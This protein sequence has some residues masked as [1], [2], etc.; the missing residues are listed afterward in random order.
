[1][2]ET[3][4]RDSL[5]PASFRGVAFEVDRTSMPTGQ[6]GQLHEFV[7]RDEPYFEQ[8]GKRA[9]VHKLTAFV[10]GPDCF[11]RRDKLLEALETQGAG[12]LVHP[13]FGRMLVKVGECEVSHE[14]AEGGMV[15]FDL[16]LYPDQP[17]KYPGAKPNT[18]QRAAKAS[19]GLLDSALGRYSSAIDRVDA[20]RINLN[21]LRSSVSGVFATVQQ[22]FS[23]IANAVNGVIGFVQA[24]VNAPDSLRS[25]FS[26]YFAG[27][28]FNLFSSG[29]SGSSYRRSLSLANQQVEA[30]RAID[31]LPPAG[32]ADTSAAAQAT[33]NLVQ[34][35]LLVQVGNIV[36]DLPVA[37][38][39][40]P[41][42]SVPPLDQQEQQPVE[43]PEVPVADDVLELRDDLNDAIW[44]A[45]LKADHAHYQALTNVRHA[46]NDH[47]TAVAASG[48]RLV[49]VTPEQT[50][51][52]LVL[53]YRRFGDAT[54][55]G[56]VVQRN[57]VR[58]P[59]FVPPRSL[60]L[61]KE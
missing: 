29:S 14:R 23:P 56:E 52:A 43:R 25:M 37:P 41:V 46:L 42:T 16:Q 30:V 45:A 10:I 1:M 34:D 47:L 20:A 13:W 54:R 8:L 35:A 6:R 58:H 21:S 17:R 48:V 61:A 22:Q 19:E 38:P 50:L 55:E 12:E 53:A 27:G 33:A 57:R 2:T 3:T 26:S 51:P 49:D 60:K 5:L 9:Q 28:S 4:W 44:Q 40:S 11:E 15:R 32:G 7:Q 39:A 36:A 18:Q 24:I 59:G 31:T